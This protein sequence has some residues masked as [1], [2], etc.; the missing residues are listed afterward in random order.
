MGMKIN[1]QTCFALSGSDSEVMTIPEGV[2]TVSDFL[3]YIGREIDFNFINPETGHLE[4]ELEIILNGKEIWFH[5][6]GLDTLLQDGYRLEIY[7]L[8]IGGG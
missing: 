7:L 3:G 8:P 5:P 1:L 2:K 4:G 6:K